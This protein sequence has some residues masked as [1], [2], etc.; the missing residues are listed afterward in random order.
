MNEVSFSQHKQDIILDNDLFNK[1]TGGVFVEIGAY[2]GV[3]F[4]NSV[5]FERFRN[6]TGICV[7]PIPAR[8]NE[9]VKNRH[10]HCENVAIDENETDFEFTWVEGDFETEMLSGWAKDESNNIRIEKNINTEKHTV[11]RIKVKAL[12]LQS[13]LDKYQVYAIDYCSIDVE[14]H[15]INVLRSID[16]KRVR[17]EVFSVEMNHSFGKCEY[18]LMR[19]GYRFV[20]TIGPDAIYKKTNFILTPYLTIGVKRL[21]KKFIR[22]FDK[23]RFTYLGNK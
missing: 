11:T 4:S 12:P 10:C 18:L 13:I 20:R 3:Q 17:I 22:L 15:E 1:K 19:K 2:D 6:W 16:F 21:I 5:F 23:S 14:G 9:L 8:F 7:E